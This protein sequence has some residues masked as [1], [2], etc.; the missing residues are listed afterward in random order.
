MLLKSLKKIYYEK[1]YNIR[2]RENSSDFNVV[3]DVLVHEQYKP[4]CIDKVENIIDAGANIGCTSIYF[5]KIYPN[6]KI[7]AIEPDEKNF[8]SLVEHTKAYPNVIPIKAGVWGE[9]KSLMVQDN[10]RGEWGRQTFEVENQE[11]APSENII[12]GITIPEIMEKFNMSKIDILKIDVEGSE[13]TIFGSNPD[14]WLS[15]VRIMAIELHDY[16]LKGCS[17]ALF[18]A[19]SKYPHLEMSIHEEDIIL[20]NNTLDD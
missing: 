5:A 19:V 14:I 16:M 7:I 20:R 4:L 3:R 11:G 1:K 12:E 6:A 9:K 18:T 2:I 10:G 8:K 15:K 13:K 17:N